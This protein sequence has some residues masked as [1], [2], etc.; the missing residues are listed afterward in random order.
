MKRLLLLIGLF[1]VPSWLGAVC[2]GDLSDRNLFG[3]EGELRWAKWIL[4]NANCTPI[5]TD[6]QKA[7]LISSTSLVNGDFIPVVVTPDMVAAATTTF[8]V[9]YDGS[10]FAGD[11]L[12]PSPLPP[13]EKL[14]AWSLQRLFT[15]KILL[16]EYIVEVQK[17]LTGT[18]LTGI[19]DGY[20]VLKIRRLQS[21]KEFWTRIYMAMP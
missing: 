11:I 3:G 21:V 5:R 20:F 8:N 4:N 18:N 2:V 12:S 9:N 1:L 6:A 16:A 14:G 17:E 7:A 15:R 10:S 13:A 19:V